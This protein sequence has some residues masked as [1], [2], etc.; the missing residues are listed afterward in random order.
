MTEGML[1][2]LDRALD[3]ERRFGAGL[4][5]VGPGQT[6]QIH[7][8]RDLGL[9]EFWD[10]GYDIDG[11]VEGDVPIFRLTEAGRQAAEAARQ[12]A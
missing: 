7:R 5:P 6:K 11:E 4:F 2:C 10:F 1:G 3:L 12:P 9:L 8:L